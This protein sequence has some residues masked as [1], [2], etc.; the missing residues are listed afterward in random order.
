VG[1]YLGH[2]GSWICR[3]SKSCGCGM[4]VGLGVGSVGGSSTLRNEHVLF[5]QCSMF[6]TSW[7]MRS[8]AAECIYRLSGLASGDFAP[9]LYLGSAPIQP[10]HVCP[11]PPYLQTLATL[12]RKT[13]VRACA[14]CRFARSRPSDFC[15]AFD[16]MRHSIGKQHFSCTPHSYF[17]SRRFRS[18]TVTK[19]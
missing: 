16:I 3:N 7:K 2:S 4:W 5:S 14:V 11:P 13:A 9:D 18:M 10:D 6:Y 19:T 1:T 12:L 8:S 15:F 17:I